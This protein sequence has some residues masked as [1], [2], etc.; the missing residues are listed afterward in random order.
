MSATNP[1]AK[2]KQDAGARKPPRKARAKQSQAEQTA[3]GQGALPDQRRALI[4][5]LAYFRAEQ[6]GFTGGDP[7]AD[8]LTSEREVDELLSRQADA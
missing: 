4:A 2:P 6:R 7:V 1:A 5:E 8:W 3:S